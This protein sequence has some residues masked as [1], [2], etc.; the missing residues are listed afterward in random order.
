MPDVHQLP[1]RQVNQPRGDLYASSEELAVIQAQ[2]VV[3]PALAMLIWADLILAGIEL[4]LRGGARE[5][6]GI[7]KSISP[8]GRP[9]NT[10]R[11]R[12]ALPGSPSNVVELRP[13]P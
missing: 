6:V 12:C 9:A 2:L 7:S 3:P 4:L 11:N 5:P 8:K 1:L 10:R 13:T